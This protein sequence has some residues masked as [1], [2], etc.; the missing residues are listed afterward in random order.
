MLDFFLLSCALGIMVSSPGP[1]V[2]QLYSY[3][4]EHEIYPAH[5]C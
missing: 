2:I 1:E 4:A 3:S 5:K